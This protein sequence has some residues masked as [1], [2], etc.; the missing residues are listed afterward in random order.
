MAKNCIVYKGSENNY[1]KK[2]WKNGKRNIDNEHDK[3]VKYGKL[4][5]KQKD[6]RHPY[7]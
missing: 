5:G 6:T 7:P 1:K 3:I 4:K 2:N